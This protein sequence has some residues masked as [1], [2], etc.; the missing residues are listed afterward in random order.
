MK[1]DE[2]NF[3]EMFFNEWKKTEGLIRPADAAKLIGV[4]RQ[5]VNDMIDDGRLKTYK[6]KNITFLGIKDISLHIHKRIGKT[7]KNNVSIENTPIQ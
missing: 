7:P 5:S 2:E 1:T 3:C 4:T 6:V